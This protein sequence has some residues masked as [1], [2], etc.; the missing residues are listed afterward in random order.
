LVDSASESGHG[1]HQPL[2]PPRHP[3][4]LDAGTAFSAWWSGTGPERQRLGVVQGGQP[5]A[6]KRA[7]ACVNR[8]RVDRSGWQD[9]NLRP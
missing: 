9:W 3:G 4:V 2:S 8:S 1:R 6:Q 5:W 7:L